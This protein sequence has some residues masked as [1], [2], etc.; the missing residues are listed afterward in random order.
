MERLFHILGG[1]GGGSPVVEPEAGGR[2]SDDEASATAAEAQKSLD[3][4]AMFPTRAGDQAIGSEFAGSDDEE[5]DGESEEGG[6]ENIC[7]Y[8]QS[9]LLI[10]LATLASLATIGLSIFVQVMPWSYATIGKNAVYVRWICM[11]GTIVPVYYVVRKILS[12]VFVL[13]ELRLFRDSLAYLSNLKNAT[14]NMAFAYVELAIFYIVFHVAFCFGKFEKTCDDPVYYA[15]SVIGMQCLL[16]LGLFFTASWL[17]CL[18][19]KML[20]THFYKSTHF[21]KFR[22]A[23]NREYVLHA[24]SMPKRKVIRLHHNQAGA[25]DGAHPVREPGWPTATPN[26]AAPSSTS[27]SSSVAININKPGTPRAEESRDMRADA[28]VPSSIPNS[29][30]QLNTVAEE[31][32]EPSNHLLKEAGLAPEEEEGAMPSRLLLSDSSR[33]ENVLT[34]D[35]LRA[36]PMAVNEEVTIEELD[37]EDKLE[38]LRTAVVVKTYSK[39][40]HLYKLKPNLEMESRM[41]RRVKAFSRALFK[42]MS[43]HGEHAAREY[44]TL[45]DFEHFFEPTRQGRAEAAR[46]FALF[47]WDSTGKVDREQT[48]KAVMAI[49]NQRA[50]VASALEDTDSIVQSLESGFAGGMHFLFIAFY[51]HIWGINL[52]AG[53]T[54]FSAVMVGLSFVFGNSI[55]IMFESLL[56]LFNEHPYDVGDMVGIDEQVYEV[57]KVRLLYTVMLDMYGHTIYFS[58]K[59]LLEKRVVNWSRSRNHTDYMFPEVDVGVASVVKTELRAR[60]SEHIKEYRTEYEAPAVVIMKTMTANNLKVVMMISY[61]MNFSPD[62]W[63]RLCA[64]RDSMMQI[65]SDV[66]AKYQQSGELEHTT[67]RIRMKQS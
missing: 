13:I 55:R 25:Q 27:S 38:R 35:M 14:V 15:K 45:E 6:G 19:S 44:V 9:K 24:L 41:L 60:M 42:N 32:S 50:S 53:F 5:S 40:V 2:V 17:A 48:A 16:C 8:L 49:F 52:V 29:Q 64:A 37:N 54:T 11:V 63:E 46:A 65:V 4:L 28:S 47:D 22:E 10:I 26:R 3:P 20:S 34:E 1:G 12:R 31:H 62:Q 56:F 30:P 18:A 43:W 33:L 36:V 58:S 39:L 7:Y 67:A 51:L 66:L 57:K 61:T 23:L 59:E 21:K